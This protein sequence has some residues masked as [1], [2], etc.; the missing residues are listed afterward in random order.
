[1]SLSSV[2]KHSGCLLEQPCLGTMSFYL[3]VRELW[4]IGGANASGSDSVSARELLRFDGGRQ[5]RIERTLPV[6]F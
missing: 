1:M 6:A 2:A 3:G 4:N 5:R